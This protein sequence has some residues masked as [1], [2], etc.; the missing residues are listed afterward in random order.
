MEENNRIAH[1]LE[2]LREDKA[3][4]EREYK[5]NEGFKERVNEII[6]VL[7]SMDY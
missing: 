2:A 4:I 1:E 3:Q 5:I 7:D 6:A